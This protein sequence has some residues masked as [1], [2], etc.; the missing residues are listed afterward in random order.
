MNFGSIFIRCVPNRK[1]RLTEIDELIESLSKEREELVKASIDDQLIQPGTRVIVYFDNPQRAVAAYLKA[2]YY[3]E[4][5]HTLHPCFFEMSADGSMG[6]KQIRDG[7]N[8]RG[9]E[10]ASDIPDL[11]KFVAKINKQ[12]KR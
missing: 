1:E 9:F 4:M 7:F 12:F 10:D 11:K 3:D 5:R 2:Y 6:Y 8:A